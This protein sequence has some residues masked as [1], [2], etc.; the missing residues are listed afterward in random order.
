M[1]TP[2]VIRR[3]RDLVLSM[4]P[5]ARV[6]LAPA[7]QAIAPYLR[8][9][10]PLLESLKLFLNARVSGRA[11]QPVPSDPIDCRASLERDHEVRWLITRLDFI[12][13]SPVNPPAGED[14]E[15]PA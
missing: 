7:E 8:G 10:T 14:G 3:V 13:R 2:P 1:S 5:P 11:S 12:Y 15:P 6:V 4:L 9:T